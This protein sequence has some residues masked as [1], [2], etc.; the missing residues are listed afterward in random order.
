MMGNRSFAYTKHPDVPYRP[1][2]DALFGSLAEHW[3]QP[4]LAVLLTGMGRDG[5]EGMKRLRQNGWN[6]VAQDE[7]TSIVFGM[8]KAAIEVGAAEHVLPLPEIAAA[9][10]RMCR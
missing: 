8:P 4:G 6:T 3:S 7:S 9:V 5:A 1:S 10:I 2:V